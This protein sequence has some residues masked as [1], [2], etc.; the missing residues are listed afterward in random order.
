MTDKDYEVEPPSAVETD[1]YG[2]SDP[3]APLP[4]RSDSWSSAPAWSTRRSLPPEPQAAPPPRRPRMLGFVAVAIAAGIVAGSLSGLAVVNFVGLNEGA[5]PAEVPAG[6]TVEQVT[7]DETSAVIEAVN[8]V[9]PAVVTINVTVA[10]GGSGSGSGFIFDPDGWILTNRH[11]AGDASSMIVTLADSRQFDARLI[12]VDTL[13]DLAIIKIDA[14]GLPTAPIGTSASLEI[15]QK[16]IAIGNPLGDYADTVTTG[17]V[18]G[19]GRQIVAGDGLSSEALNHLIQTDAA[20]NP[21]NSGGPLVNSIGQVIGINTAIAT[22]AEGIGFAVP[23]DFAKPIMALALNGEEI[24]RPYIGV[25]YTMITLQ[26]AEDEDLPVEDG[27]LVV[28]GAN[29]QPAVSPGSP[30]EEA[31]LQEGDIITALGGRAVED[32]HD[33]VVLL[34]PYRPGNTVTLTVLRGGDELEIPVTL[35]TLPPA[36]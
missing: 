30:A 21:G 33:L 10:T 15:G 13:T 17:V 16:A 18:S 23:I 24:A 26:L 28:A 4:A 34:L 35:G 20:I 27:A 36:S 5:P 12:G 25:R 29:G 6:D 3:T 32:E 7:L 8:N 9:A 31:G 19:L 2:A 14:T 11:V 22:S 1:R